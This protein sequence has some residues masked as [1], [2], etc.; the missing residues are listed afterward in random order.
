MAKTKK[1]PFGEGGRNSKLPK[2]IIP[3]NALPLASPVTS[4]AVLQS[5]RQKHLMMATKTDPGKEEKIFVQDVCK[6][7]FTYYVDL[8]YNR[9]ISVT[10]IAS[11]RKEDAEEYLFKK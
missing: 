8:S 4:L 2:K 5:N 7:G 9:S 6:R 3:A 10:E 1:N 11:L